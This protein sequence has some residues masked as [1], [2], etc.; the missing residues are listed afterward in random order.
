V[1]AGGRA[2]AGVLQ[3]EA[4]QRLLRKRLTLLLSPPPQAAKSN[5][6]DGST[7][8]VTIHSALNAAASLRGKNLRRPAECRSHRTTR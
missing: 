3:Y 4:F 2:A 5:D 6:D 1:R 8:N 7:W